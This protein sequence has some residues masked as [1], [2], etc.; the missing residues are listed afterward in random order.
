MFS[1][2]K[3]VFEVSRPPRGLLGA[4]N[5]KIGAFS[6]EIGAPVIS[7]TKRVGKKCLLTKLFIYNS[8]TT[9]VFT[10]HNFFFKNFS[11]GP[12]DPKTR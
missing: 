3:I 10:S 12:P 4:Q 5:P 8:R 6:L 2:F 1:T 11:G 7:E 9:F